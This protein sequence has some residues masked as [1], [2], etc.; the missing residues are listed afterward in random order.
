[1]LGAAVCRLDYLYYGQTT[2]NHYAAQYL[3]SKHF[4]AGLLFNYVP[5]ATSAGAQY[6]L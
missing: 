6:Y 3:F 1:M 5:G 4:S 2:Q